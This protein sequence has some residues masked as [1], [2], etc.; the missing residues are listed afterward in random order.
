[1]KKLRLESIRACFEGV[2]PATMATC[3][4]DGVPNTAYL[5]QVHFV[6][7]RHVALSYQF[8]NKTRENILANPVAAL[9]VTN[10]M[11]AE[12]YQL[13]LR[14]LRTETSG[15]LFESMKAKL[16]GI[17]AHTGMTG[18]FR[19]LGSDL[20]EVTDIEQVV[21]ARLP[22]EPPA[23]NL[24]SALRIFTQR[25]APCSDL[26]HMLSETL[27]CLRE[28]FDIDHA[29]LL[30]LDATRK[31]LYTV[32]SQGYEESG[33][34][35]EIPLGQ[36]VIGIA[37][38]EGTPIRIGHMNAEYAYSRA[39]KENTL[40][41]GWEGN[42]ET[43]IP[44]PGLKE[45]RSQLAIPIRACA[46][47]LGVLYVESAQDLRFSYD[48]EDALVT[49]CAQLGLAIDRLQNDT[50]EDDVTAPPSASPAAGSPV[51]V[52]YF[53]ENGS[54][55]LNDDYLIKGV[56]G[57][58]FWTLLQDYSD[59]RRVSFTNRELRL[60]SRIRLPDVSD[61]LEARL[62]LLS[63]RLQERDA[64]VRIEKAGRGRFQLC[65]ACPVQLVPG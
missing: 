49:L 25:L 61:N 43:E 64:C 12:Q 37:A 63:R 32:A 34:G 19:L 50:G 39:V 18:I 7:E 47:V 41:S 5:S 28:H 30:M 29:M 9:L 6:D 58:I 62:V 42:F 46:T 44:L 24:L 16:A 15:P 35:S 53:S 60:D 11:T 52:R 31:T 40:M 51:Q 17:A 26:D 33:V 55:F 13:S 54:V 10:P 2:V 57:A 48:D 20:Y 65:V 22:A 14:Y 56:A 4:L 45:P 1:M 27:S 59:K 38:R 3:D 21:A 23:R 36:G 8:F